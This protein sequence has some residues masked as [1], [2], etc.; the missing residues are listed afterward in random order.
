MAGFGGAQLDDIV[1]GYLATYHAGPRKMVVDNAVDADMTDLLS[2]ERWR[3]A[4]LRDADRD[5]PINIE[6]LTRLCAIG[7]SDAQCGSFASNVDNLTTH[8]KSVFQ[9]LR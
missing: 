3:I 8:E 6:H 1:R 7:L 5:R 4:F 9:A 2:A